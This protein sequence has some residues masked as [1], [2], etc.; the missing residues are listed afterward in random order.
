MWRGGDKAQDKG[1]Y[2]FKGGY[3]W[4]KIFGNIYISILHKEFEAIDAR[5]D[6]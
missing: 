1:W 2:T 5:E 6:N 4:R 3:F